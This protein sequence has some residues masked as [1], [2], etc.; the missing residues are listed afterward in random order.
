MT[1]GN[2]QSRNADIQA[3][4]AYGESLMPALITDLEKSHNPILWWAGL[5]GHFAGVMAATIGFDATKA[6]LHVTIGQTDAV[7]KAAGVDEA[8]H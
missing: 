6:L 4:A 2:Q 7:G 1:M 3:G 8:V 5:L